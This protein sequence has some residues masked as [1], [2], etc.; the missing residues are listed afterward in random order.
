LLRKVI[1]LFERHDPNY[2]NSIS[3]RIADIFYHVAWK[4]HQNYAFSQTPPPNRVLLPA[5]LPLSKAWTIKGE[6]K[7][8]PYKAPGSKQ[9]ESSQIPLYD[10]TTTA[11]S[12]NYLLHHQY[13]DISGSGIADQFPDLRLD[14]DLMPTSSHM[15][16]TGHNQGVIN[17]EW[18]FSFNSDP[19]RWEGVWTTA[20]IPGEEVS[21][22][23][24]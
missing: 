6:S 10:E 18:R 13:T 21:Y 11:H 14:D 5:D 17:N 2:K 3:F 16:C 7:T 15:A 8:V 1:S 9:L 22:A 24:V 23:Q 20:A 19:Q 12:S 4:A